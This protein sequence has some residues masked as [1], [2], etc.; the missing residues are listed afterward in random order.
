[1]R[2]KAQAHALVVVRNNILQSREARIMVEAARGVGPEAVQRRCP[3]T[4]VRRSV[5]LKVVR[6]NFTRGM[7]VPTR[8]GIKRWHMTSGALS[9]SVEDNFA[10]FGCFLVETPGGWHGSG[11]GE[12]IKQKRSQLRR[13]Q[14]RR[15]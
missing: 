8:L 12:L 13:N 5:G 14:I 3:V 6:T 11:N 9:A 4:F 15:I 1:M 10:S 7:H 2:R